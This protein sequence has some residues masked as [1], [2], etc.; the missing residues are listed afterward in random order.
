MFESNNPYSPE[1]EAPKPTYQELEQAV[2]NL[3]SMLRESNAKTQRLIDWEYKA[4]K[5]EEW[6]DEEGESLTK[7]QVEEIC[8]IFG[9]DTDITKTVSVSVEFELEIKAPRGFDFSDLDENSFSVSI[10]QDGYEDWSISNEDG[11]ITD[12]SVED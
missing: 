5:L 8:E 6:L 11:S 2:A 1:G 3:N 4:E 9:F 10:S 12:V 7:R